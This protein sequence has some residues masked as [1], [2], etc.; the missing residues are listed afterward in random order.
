MCWAADGGKQGQ[1]MGRQGIIEKVTAFIT[2]ESTNGRDLLLFKH[3]NA[4]VQIPAGTVEDGETPKEAIL[5]EIAEEPGLKSL[6]VG[7][8]L[9]CKG[10]RLGAG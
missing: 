9:G 7:Q 5:R 8:Y 3:P 2:H 10:Q 4:G 6:S 1:E